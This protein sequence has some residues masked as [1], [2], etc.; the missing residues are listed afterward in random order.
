MVRK[1]VR[2]AA[3]L[4]LPVFLGAAPVHAAPGDFIA[5]FGADVL[6][7][8][9]SGVGLGAAGKIFVN[10]YGNGDLKTFGPGLDFLE[11]W[12]ATHMDREYPQYS[13]FFNANGIAVHGDRVYVANTGH[14]VVKVYT[15]AGE[16]LFDITYPAELACFW[17]PTAL[18][19]DA[20]GNLYVADDATGF[21][22]ENADPPVWAVKRSCG[23]Q[24]VVF[25]P[26]G[27]F[28]RTVGSPGTD[29][30]R[31][32]GADPNTL[33][34]PEGVAVDA[35]GQVYVADGHRVVIYSPAGV[36]LR[37]FEVEQPADAWGSSM[38][39]AVDGDGRIYV[40]DAWNHRVQ[41]FSNDGTVLA[42]W[43]GPGGGDGQFNVPMGVTLDPANARFFVT[44]MWNHRIQILEAFPVS[45]VVDSG[46]KG[47]L[48]PVSLDKPFQAG[49]TIPVGFSVAQADG[50][51]VDETRVAVSLR[52]GGDGVASA[53]VNCTKGGVCHANL[54]TAGLAPGAWTIVVSLP[55]G[56][57]EIKTIT[58]K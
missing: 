30:D 13:L 31:T 37:T 48:P 46:F 52:Q 58:L 14:N 34:Y 47:F 53:A 40:S 23:G 33:G 32:P 18:G 15:T 35:G 8:P 56:A 2:T 38:A 55:G 16:F 44:D 20:A 9:L 54:N 36:W 1:L 12:D 22:W 24:I 27:L 39:L 11:S 25:S 51:P 49:S 19:T 5:A 7:Y 6:N 41:V 57:E 21:V 28:L 4:L 42:T 29:P 45:A 3:A 26:D 43:G 17:N 50:A 10:D